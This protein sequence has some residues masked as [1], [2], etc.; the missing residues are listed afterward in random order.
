MSTHK[1]KKIKKLKKHSDHED[2]DDSEEE[3][4]DESQNHYKY[5]DFVVQDDQVSEGEDERFPLNRSQGS[6]SEAEL[7]ESFASSDYEIIGKEKGKKKKL[8]KKNKDKNEKVQIK[9]EEHI[10]DEKEFKSPAGTAQ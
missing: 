8:R 6:K 9:S 1:S 3:E 5:D 7:D 2:D 4:D 10:K